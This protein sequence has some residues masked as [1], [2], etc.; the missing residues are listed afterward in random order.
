MIKI[1]KNVY[2][3]FLRFALEN[4]NPLEHPRKWKECIGLILGRINNQEVLVTDIIPIGS[5]TNVFVDIADYEKVFSLISVSRINQGEVIVGWA[6]THPGLG[7][8]FS[9][10]DIQTQTMYQQMHPLAFGLVLDPT[11]I[12]STSSGFNI[13]RVDR[14]GSHVVSINYHIDETLNFLDTRQQLIEELFLKPEIP[15]PEVPILISNTEVS[16]RNIEIKITG[17]PNIKLKQSFQIGIKIKLPFRQYIRIGYH[18]ESGDLVE[19]PFTLNLIPNRNIF[20]ETLTSGTLAIYTIHPIN[21]GVTQI[22]LNNLMITDYKEKNVELPEIYLTTQ[23]Q[24]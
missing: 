17:P 16:W 8:F 4:A 1:P 6:H 18:I 10:T 11:K 24:D 22:K 13:Y 3:K 12:T 14:T 9:S 21:V 20:H 2:R 15:Y 7:L 19:D 23:I 5:G